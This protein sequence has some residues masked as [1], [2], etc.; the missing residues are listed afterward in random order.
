MNHFR[1]LRVLPEPQKKLHKSANV[2]PHLITDIQGQAEAKRALQIA[3]AGGHHMLMIGASGVGKSMLARV[4]VALLP[5]LSPQESMETAM[6]YSTSNQLTQGISCKPPFRAPHHTSSVSGIVGGSAK[7]L[8]GEISLAHNGILFLDEFP[9]FD[10][11]VIESLRCV[12]ETGEVSIVRA[13]NRISYPARFLLIAA[14]NPCKC[15]YLGNP[16][17]E[18]LCAQSYNNKYIAKISGPILDRFSIV[19][20]V[21]QPRVALCK[22]ETAAEFRRKITV[23]RKAQEERFKGQK[24]NTNGQISGG[25]VNKFVRLSPDA[26][27]AIDRAIAEWDLSFVVAIVRCKLL[28]L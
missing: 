27:N 4:A 13:Q 22:Q 5:L 9:E 23:A 15:G 24:F 28:V 7:A 6:V 11:R 1:G 2:A 16:K 21:K 25:L 10:K 18:C 14:M 12:L 20:Y 17:R 26:Q 19:T 8:P 3:C